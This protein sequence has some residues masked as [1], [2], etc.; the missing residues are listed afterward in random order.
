MFVLI[1]VVAAMF[2]GISW[3]L[4][5][6]SLTMT[7]TVNLADEKVVFKTSAVSDSHTDAANSVSH[8][9][10]TL[11]FSV[12]FANVGESSTITFTLHNTSS[13]NNGIVTGFNITGTNTSSLT[14]TYVTDD[15]LLAFS[16]DDAGGDLSYRE[17]ILPRGTTD[18]QIL[19]V[20]WAGNAALSGSVVFTITAN[21]SWAP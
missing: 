18:P 11:T 17:P 3:A 1:A 13:K 10:D 20:T 21:W 5:N 8:T 7:G 19:T 4:A 15:V 2:V 16:F 12:N 9:D 6:G 14:G